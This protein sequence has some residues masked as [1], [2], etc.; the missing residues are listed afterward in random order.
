MHFVTEHH[1]SSSQFTKWSALLSP[2]PLQTYVYKSMAKFLHH[3]LKHLMIT[4]TGIL[5]VTVRRQLF[6]V[7]GKMGLYAVTCCAASLELLYST[8]SECLHG[9][10]E[11]L[12]VH[13]N[14]KVATNSIFK[15]LHYYNGSHFTGILKTN[16][17]H[18]EARILYSAALRSVTQSLALTIFRSI[19]Q[20]QTL[21]QTLINI[22]FNGVVQ[23]YIKRIR[24]LMLSL[25]P[26]ALSVY[27]SVTHIFHVL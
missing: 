6:S 11:M 26:N 9:W 16:W 17:D 27:L 15:P 8:G 14:R 3:I 23:D 24:L 1:S 7:A 22:I 5:G 2:S 25:G 19:Y 13:Q 20:G 12:L 21:K 4:K 10:S 18:V